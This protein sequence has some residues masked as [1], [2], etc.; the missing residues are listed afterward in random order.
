MTPFAKAITPP[1]TLRTD[2]KD[3]MHEL[4]CKPR[5]KP[6]YP[7]IELLRKDIWDAQIAG[8]KLRRVNNPMTS[9]QLRRA[10]L[11][12]GRD[13][14]HAGYAFGQCNPD[15]YW[16]VTVPAPKALERVGSGYL[17]RDRDYEAK[18]K[19]YRIDFA[20]AGVAPVRHL[21]TSSPQ[22]NSS[23]KINEAALGNGMVSLTCLPRNPDWLGWV[24]WYLAPTGSGPWAEFPLSEMIPA[25]QRNANLVLPWVN[26]VRTQLQ[27]PEL[28]SGIDDQ[29]HARAISVL[30]VSK[31]VHHNRKLLGDISR[32]LAPQYKLNGEDR[33]RGS[34]LREILWLLWNSPRHRELILNPTATHLTLRHQVLAQD[35]FMAIL[36]SQKREPKP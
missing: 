6:A 9:E 3:K 33:V 26:A 34:S 11:D 8:Q 35:Q 1:I 15:L 36:I 23:Y 19:G 31:N 17:V 13:Q 12:L 25:G 10:A 16:I 21:Y 2:L 22:W 29:A 32:M 27:L 20:P 24:L 5:P 28:Q 4:I 30:S 14:F 7:A 18:C